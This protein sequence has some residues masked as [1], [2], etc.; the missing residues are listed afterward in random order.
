MLSSEGF[1]FYCCVKCGLSDTERKQIHC[2]IWQRCS[3]GSQAIDSSPAV[4]HPHGALLNLIGDLGVGCKASAFVENTD[5]RLMGNAPGFGTQVCN[6][7]V[8]R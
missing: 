3:T 8:I 5:G 4:V 7:G 2:R 1:N 6:R